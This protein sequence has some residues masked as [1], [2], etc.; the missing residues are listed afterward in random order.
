MGWKYGFLGCRIFLRLLTQDWR[1][2]NLHENAKYA[3][4][5]NGI[6]TSRRR[7]AI[8]FARAS[9]FNQHSQLHDAA[10]VLCTFSLIGLQANLWSTQVE[11]PTDHPR[12]EVYTFQF[13]RSKP[14]L[15]SSVK[16]YRASARREFP[17]LLTI[18]AV[19]IEQGVTELRLSVFAMR[20]RPV[21]SALSRQISDA[22]SGSGSLIAASTRTSKDRTSATLPSKVRRQSI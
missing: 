22:P 5:A 3:D 15:W 14:H 16:T 9:K 20:T 7:L 12:R 18:L 4:R 2:T 21:C 19:M 10:P 13:P 17:S 1:R 11:E 8:G 6:W